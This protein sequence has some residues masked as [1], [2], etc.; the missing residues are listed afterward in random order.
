LA[1]RHRRG[2]PSRTDSGGILIRRGGDADAAAIAEIWLRSFAAT[3]DFP[4]A[5][6]D[7]DVRRWVRDDLVPTTE[8]W[9]AV[10]ERSARIVG[11]MALDGDDLGQL[12]LDPAWLRRGIGSRLVELAKT[13]RPGGLGLFTFQVNAGARAFYERHGFRT[14]WLGDGSANEER[15]PDL[16]MA[17]SPH[18]ERLG[19]AR[20]PR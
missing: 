10:D 19:S 6:P 20:A 5:H 4:P 12:Y 3:Y 14:V 16:R 17:W 1:D 9:V 8:V 15:Q 11:F 18:S 7:D 2:T 13:R